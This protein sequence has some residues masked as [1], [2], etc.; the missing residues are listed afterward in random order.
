MSKEKKVALITGA[1][2]G[3]GKATAIQL[4][5]TGFYDG[6]QEAPISPKANEFQY[7]AFGEYYDEYFN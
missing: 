6:R 4:R 1:S 7:E 3:I 5:N 2:S